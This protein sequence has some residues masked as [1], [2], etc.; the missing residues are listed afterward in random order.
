[1]G[2]DKNYPIYFLLLGSDTRQVYL[3]F[4]LSYVTPT[5]N[6]ILFYLSVYIHMY[7]CICNIMFKK[8]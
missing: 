2:F 8:K 3:M 6:L 7:V 1:M 4:Q 5:Q